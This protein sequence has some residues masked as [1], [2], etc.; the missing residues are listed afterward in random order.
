MGRISSIGGIGGIG[1]SPRL[2]YSEGEQAYQ[3]FSSQLTTAQAWR[4]ARVL[5]AQ[6]SWQPLGHVALGLGQ[7]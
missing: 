6:C 7:G 4:A 2:L 3:Q 1:S 5:G